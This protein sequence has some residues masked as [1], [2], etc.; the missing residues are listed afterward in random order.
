MALYLYWCR[1][2]LGPVRKR[3]FCV[4]FQKLYMKQY[5]NLQRAYRWTGDVSFYNEGL[6]DI[7]MRQYGCCSKGEFQLI[8][9]MLG[10]R[11]SMELGIF[12]EESGEGINLF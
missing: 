7:W 12:P 1:R 4:G 10:L 5:V 3:I 11:R 9:C 6:C 8:E 2:L